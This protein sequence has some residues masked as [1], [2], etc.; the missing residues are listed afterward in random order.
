MALI[1]FLSFFA[2]DQAFD[3]K[4]SK[5]V[6][7]S[8]QPGNP[9]EENEDDIGAAF[10]NYMNATKSA[11]SPVGAAHSRDGVKDRGK[12]S[13]GNFVKADK[14]SP[15]TKG[16]PTK[17]VPADKPAFKEKGSHSIGK[18]VTMPANLSNRGSSPSGDGKSKKLTLNMRQ[19]KSSVER[20]IY[21]GTPPS[22]PEDEKK[23][24]LARP[25]TP[26]TLDD[27]EN[28]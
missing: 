19:S 17:E 8:A 4:E 13:T 7:E 23:K 15:A 10:D 26:P 21:E 24:V 9:F 14:K 18:S 2:A 27:T 25:I 20:P 1:F 11:P 22:T 16:S 3:K 5:V 6:S 12:K 28:K